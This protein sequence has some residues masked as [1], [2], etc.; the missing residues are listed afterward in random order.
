MMFAFQTLFAQDNHQA[1]EM[2]VYSGIIESDAAIRGVNFRQ[3]FDYIRMKVSILNNNQAKVEIFE[4]GRG[5]EEKPASVLFKPVTV[6]NY[7]KRGREL[8]ID[9]G[10]SF[11]IGVNS[12]TI[13]HPALYGTLSLISG[14][15]FLSKEQMNKKTDSEGTKD[16]DYVDLGLPSGTKWATYNVGASSPTEYGDYF[17]WGE[18]KPKEYYSG[19]TYKWCVGSYHRTTKYCA[20]SRYC[21]VDDNKTVLD[22]EDDAATANWGSAWRMPTREEIEELRDGCS[23]K[24]V[25]D[26]NGSGVNGRLGTSKKN[27]STI[28]LPAA[29]SNNSGLAQAGSSGRYWS[30]S[31]N[32]NSVEAVSLDFDHGVM[33]NI[34]YFRHIGQCVRAVLR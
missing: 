33:Y 17:A 10:M 7:H 22:A 24:W 12:L 31:L 8:S 34:G 29:G 30:S 9:Q 28:F 15:D 6:S 14:D 18:T 2:A 27:G 13:K 1:K 16:Y 23:W 3:M 21:V 4:K 19:S 5:A 25:E 11:S 20:D 26:F 32:A